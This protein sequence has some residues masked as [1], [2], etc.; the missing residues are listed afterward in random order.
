MNYALGE[1]LNPVTITLLGQPVPWARTQGGK[2]GQRF[3]PARQR[4]NAATLR[5]AAMREMMFDA[6]KPFEEA[7]R[8]TILAE[9]QIPK[10]WP[11]WRKNGAILGE[12]PHSSKPDLDNIIKQIKD[13]FKG[14]VYRDD[15]LVSEISAKKRYGVQPKLVITVSQA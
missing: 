8:L 1:M 9:F 10:S 6:H 7:V 15:A 5:M 4:N 13:A 2:T 3:T 14:V 11:K 12:S